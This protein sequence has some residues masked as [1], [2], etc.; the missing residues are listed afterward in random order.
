MLQQ[1]PLAVTWEPPS[2]EIFPPLVAAVHE[3]F[4]A[5]AVEITGNTAVDL[6]VT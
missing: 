2:E 6:A 4:D 5:T 1:T 3:I